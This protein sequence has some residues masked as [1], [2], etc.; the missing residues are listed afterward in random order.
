MKIV[1]VWKQD[2]RILA[3]CTGP[4]INREFLCKEISVGG[5]QFSVAGIDILTS[6]S[7][8]VNAVLQIN[9]QNVTSVPLGDFE[10]IR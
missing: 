3:Y 5:Q 6:V 9:V 7:G 4:E 10:I 2:D 8:T 1:D